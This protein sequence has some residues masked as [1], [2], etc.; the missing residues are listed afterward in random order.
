[1]AKLDKN[2][3]TLKDIT[4]K[5]K[6]YGLIQLYKW[7]SESRLEYLKKEQRR[8]AEDG[9]RKAYLVRKNGMYSLFVDKVA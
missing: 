9:T 8:I 5:I 1:M 3:Y 6:Q 2:I 4:D 7:L